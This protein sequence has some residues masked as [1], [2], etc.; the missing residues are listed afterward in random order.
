M[1]DSKPAKKSRLIPF[2]ILAGAGVFVAILLLL[3]MM[4]HSV[5]PDYRIAVVT[6]M[7]LSEQNVQVLKNNLT[8]Y[9][10]DANEDGQVYIEVENIAVEDTSVTKNAQQALRDVVDSDDT[11]LFL[12]DRAE[13]EYIL[14]GWPDLF[15]TIQGEEGDQWPLEGSSFAQGWGGYTQTGLSLSFSIRKS[16]GL[17]GDALER[18]QAARDLLRAITYDP[19]PTSE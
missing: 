7:G 11:F 5:E 1:S 10:E 2:L 16:D 14:A 8:L 15:S 3:L 18:Y 6:P 19:D 12:T 4:T 9:A 17:T 13:Y